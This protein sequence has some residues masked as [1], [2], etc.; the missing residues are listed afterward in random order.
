MNLENCN[1]MVKLVWIGKRSWFGMEKLD[2]N[3]KSWME[4]LKLEGRLWVWHS[5]AG[6]DGAEEE[7]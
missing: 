5:C 7:C 6:V 3:G 1:G 2:W 4:W